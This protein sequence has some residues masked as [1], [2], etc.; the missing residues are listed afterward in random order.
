MS[1]DEV[2]ILR[3][4]IGKLI[5]VNSFLSTSIDRRAALF[6]LG[7]KTDDVEQSLIRNRS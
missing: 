4:S 3:N 7:D 2:D 6:F 1:K 5:S